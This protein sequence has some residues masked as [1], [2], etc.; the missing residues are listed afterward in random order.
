MSSRCTLTLL[1]IAVMTS[2]PDMVKLLLDT[3]KKRQPNEWSSTLNSFFLGDM[4]NVT[5][6]NGQTPLHLAVIHNRRKIVKLLLEYEEIILDIQ[7]SNGR[8]ALDI[9]K[10]KNNQDIINMLQAKKGCTPDIFDNMLNIV[11]GLYNQAVIYKMNTVGRDN[12]FPAYCSYLCSV[13]SGKLNEVIDDVIAC[14]EST[15][16]YLRAHSFIVLYC[17]SNELDHLGNG[18]SLLE[19]CV[20]PYLDGSLYYLREVSKIIIYGPKSTMDTVTEPENVGRS[21]A[22]INSI[23]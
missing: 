4:I 9:A 13:T 18:L 22:A 15:N 16:K 14:D 23:D 10:S 7:D 17:I 1:H 19:D 5:D 8:T 11:S 3:Y 21:L 6:E 20:L 12:G 2:S